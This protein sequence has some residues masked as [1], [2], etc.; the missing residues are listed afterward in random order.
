MGD[1]LKIL[2]VYVLFLILVIFISKTSTAQVQ[3]LYINAD[4]NDNNKVEW[5]DELDSC[6]IYYIQLCKKH[7]MA[8]EY[9]ITVIP[10]IILLVDNKEVKRFEA[11]LSFKMIATKEEV[12]EEINKI[13]N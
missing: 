7:Y 8:K 5:I 9:K 2:C 11:D 13:I 3:V 4:W 10:A 1:S 6:D 12:Q